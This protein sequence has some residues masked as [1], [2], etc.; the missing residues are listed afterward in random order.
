VEGNHRM[1]PDYVKELPFLMG[2]GDVPTSLSLRSNL[3]RFHQGT[4]ESK[5]CTYDDNTDFNYL[6]FV[7]HPYCVFIIAEARLNR[8]QGKARDPTSKDLI[9]GLEKAKDAHMTAL[10]QSSD[11]PYLSNYIPEID[12][13]QNPNKLQ[14]KLHPEKIAISAEERKLLVEDDDLSKQKADATAAA[15]TPKKKT[16]S[17][18]SQG[19]G[20]YH[21]EVKPQRTSAQGNLDRGSCEA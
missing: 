3:K 1:D 8:I 15:A 14:R 6:N 5:G 17:V 4:R 18:S 13:V 19:D 12:N 7:S 9:K 20:D 11:L 21:A 16:S 10:V 2:Q